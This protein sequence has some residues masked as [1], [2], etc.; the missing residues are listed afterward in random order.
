MCQSGQ[1]QKLASSY[2]LESRAY[3]N[4]SFSKPS[5]CLSVQACTVQ[6]LL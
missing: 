5:N 4:N 1:Y 6:T 2:D 3:L